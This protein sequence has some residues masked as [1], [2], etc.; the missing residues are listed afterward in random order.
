MSPWLEVA[1][2]V[3]VFLAA[4]FLVELFLRKKGGKRGGRSAGRV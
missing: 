2:A 4:N 1:I 3:A